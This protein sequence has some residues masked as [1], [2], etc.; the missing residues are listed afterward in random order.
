MGRLDEAIAEEKRALQLD[1]LSLLINGSLGLTFYEA[2]QYEQAIE[3]EQ[4]TLDLDPNYLIARIGL[5]LAYIQKSMYQEGIAELEKAVTISGGAAP[6][7]SNLGYAY[8]RVGRRAEAQKEL[9]KL[10]ELAKKKYVPAGSRAR[11]YAGLGDKDK[12]FQWLETAYAERSIAGTLLGMIKVDPVFDPL[13]SDPRFT[14][15]L[16]RMNLTP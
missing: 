2:R 5:G 16:R 12:T 10:E 6:A 1:P 14:D 4:K 8:A 11:I 7:L 9:D 13:R 3:Q 15:L